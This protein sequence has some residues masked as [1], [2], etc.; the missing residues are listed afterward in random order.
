MDWTAVWLTLRLA[1]CATVLLCLLGLPIAYWLA[2]STWR[3]KF[4]IEAAVALPLVPPPT[5]LGFYLLLAMGPHSPFGQS[6]ASLTGHFLPFSF[7]GPLVASVLYSFPFAVQPF[8]SAF[9]S[10]DHDL[11]HVSWPL[12]SPVSARSSVL[13]YP[14]HVLGS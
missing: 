7:Q 12:A 8:A 4:L 5:V 11:V 1:A 14:C 13:S 2:M 9:A 3:W 10:V 6:Y